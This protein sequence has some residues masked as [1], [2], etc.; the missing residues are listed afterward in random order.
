MTTLRKIWKPI[1]VIFLFLVTVSNN[2]LATTVKIPFDATSF[3]GVPL[4]INNPYWPLIEGTSFAYRAVAADEC[5]FNKM[6]VT[7]DTYYLS[8]VGVT[9]HVI[10]DQEWIT[11]QD[12]DG[13]C[14]TSTARLIEDTMDYYAQDIVGNIWYMG[15]N[16]WSYDDETLQCSQQGSWEAGKPAGNPDVDPAQAGIIMLA[17]PES[18][19]R[20]QQ[21]YLADEAE[22]WGAVTRTNGTVS[23]DYGDFDNCTVIKEWSPLEPGSVEHK[24]YCLNPAG[25]GLVFIEELKQ[26]TL[27]VEYIGANLPTAFPGEGDA[28]FPASALGCAP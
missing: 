25:S 9:A 4:T 3:P 22:D 20:Y 18:G 14:D 15:E 5:E 10:H 26:K 24:H 12:D 21:E 1:G 19:L 6:V 17:S 16:T 13:N 11:E 23:I 2:A 28:N 8:D 27:Y 7:Y